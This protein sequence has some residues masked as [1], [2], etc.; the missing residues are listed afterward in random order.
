MEPHNKRFV[1]RRWK[2]KVAHVFL[3][4]AAGAVLVFVF[5]RDDSNRTEPA[6]ETESPP[7]VAASSTSA[8]S[9]ASD[10]DTSATSSTAPPVT[11]TTTTL[12]PEVAATT[13]TT[14]TT[15]TVA[16]T[17]TTAAAAPDEPPQILSPAAANYIGGLLGFLET[18]DGLSTELEEV[19]RAWENKDVAGDT[20]R[21]KYRATESALEDLVERVR[22]FHVEVRDHPAP[23][24]VVDL[25]EDHVERAA[26]LVRLA[27][28]VLA[29]LRLPRPEDGSARRAA[30]A[31]FN[32]AADGFR[33]SVN[34]LINRIEQNAGALGL[35]TSE[36]ESA[37]MPMP[38]EAAAY[39]EGLAG[40]EEEMK[41]LA[42]DI[43]AVNQAWEDKEV[44]GD[45]Y[46]AKYR[47]TESALEAVLGQ[48][49]DFHTR[50]QAHPVPSSIQGLGE[51]P[52]DQAA[53]L[54]RS[55]E[56]VLAGL[57]LPRPE[58]G[59]A[60]RAALADFNEAVRAFGNL[61]AEI[62]EMNA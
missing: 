17:T 23:A 6:I 26:R 19:N 56:G 37:D 62:V 8:V 53:R 16:A 13:S 57:R 60:R 38:D 43:N 21:A 22:A 1:R 31:D 50:V 58:D 30:L 45:T 54:V 42:V 40:F 35:T 39:I 24:Q 34:D 25:G 11:T 10:P 4:L 9:S 49:R 3:V 32:E 48:V 12:P 5:I 20:Y 18:L 7:A 51:G 27:E 44:A 55:A 41:L 46:R 2:N 36:T 14:A 28:G 61:V 59:S 15:E 33:L 52:V 29:G 47:A